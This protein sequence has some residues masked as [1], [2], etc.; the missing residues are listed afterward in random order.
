ML[1]GHPPQLLRQWGEYAVRQ[2]QARDRGWWQFRF[3]V[4]RIGLGGYSRGFVVQDEWRL[5]H[6]GRQGLGIARR[7][8]GPPFWRFRRIP[9]A[10]Y[11][12]WERRELHQRHP[13]GDVRLNACS[14]R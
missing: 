10:K 13:S 11:H 9:R 1:F 14:N 6:K 5:L 2:N 4:P 7:S 3:L 12:E 8:G